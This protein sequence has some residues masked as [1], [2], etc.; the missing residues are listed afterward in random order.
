MANQIQG[1]PIELYRKK[2]EGYKVIT[3]AIACYASRRAEV[4]GI[5]TRQAERTRLIGD[6]LLIF[7][8]LTKLT[9]RYSRPAA[10]RNPSGAAFCNT[11]CPKVLA[12]EKKVFAELSKNQP[13]IL[14]K[15]E[16]ERRDKK[17][18]I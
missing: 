11:S 1:K 12:N 5:A 17:R 4:T 13:A 18:M 9:E 10:I 14:G 2:K 15:P 7:C 8:R 16:K 3:I 6:F